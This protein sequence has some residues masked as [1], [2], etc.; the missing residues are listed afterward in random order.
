M[1]YHVMVDGEHHELELQVDGDGLRVTD[2]DEGVHVDVGSL[3]EGHAYHLLIEG[4]SV[5]VGVEEQGT[6]LSLIIGGGRYRTEVLGEREWQARSIGGSSTEGDKSV[7]AAMTG[8]VVDVLVTE[9][10]AVTPGSTL[11]ILEAMKMENEVKAEVAGTVGR[12]HVVPGQTVSL[13]DMLLE[14]E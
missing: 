10:D 8:I 13:H 1:K 5:D 4:R 7:R 3:S 9:G 14:I 2:G 6:K 11:C 12:V